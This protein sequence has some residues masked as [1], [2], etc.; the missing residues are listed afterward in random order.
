M[1]ITSFI[2]AIDSSEEKPLY[3]LV[4]DGGFCGIL[5]TIACIG[6]S[7]SSGEFESVDENGIRH[8]YDH[9]DYSWGQFLARATGTKVY[10][11][12]R[13][14]M[15]AKEYMESFAQAKD[16]WNPEKKL[17]HISLHSV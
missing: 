1:D 3:N 9:Y 15:T 12:S 10:N 16:F 4:E 17:R 7:L 6:D 8:Y 14:G 2:K 13:G 5:R 11:F